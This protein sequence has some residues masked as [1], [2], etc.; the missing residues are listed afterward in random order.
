MSSIIALIP[1]RAGSKRIPSKNIK[2]LGDHP[3]IAY[4]IAV[5]K[6]SGMFEAVY[7]VTESWDYGQVAQH[8]GADSMARSYESSLDD[9]PDIMWI[10]EFME[11]YKPKESHFAILRPTN[12]FRTVDML[13]QAWNKYDGGATWMKAIQPVTQHPYKMW[14]IASNSN[15]NVMLPF[16]GGVGH[17][18]Q[19][20]TL[21]PCWVQNGSLEIRP[22]KGLIDV[23]YYFQPFITRDIE[24]YDINDEKDWVYAEYLIKKKKALLPKVE[25]LPYGLTL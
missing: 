5:A 21:L 10:Q 9:A 20:N 3:L 1:A 13:W 14:N 23:P 8:Y 18:S 17:L 24:G 25:E 6:Q 19:S 16:C 11:W 4:T 22:T 2:R 15:N 7:V 12:P